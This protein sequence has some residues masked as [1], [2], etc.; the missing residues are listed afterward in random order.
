MNRDACIAFIEHNYFGNVRAGQ[1]EATMDC[2]TPDARVD[3]RHGDNP[4]RRF[5]VRPAR[6]ATSLVDF[7][8]HLCSNYDAWFGEFQHFIDTEANRAASHFVVR[9]TPKPA[10]LYADAG[11]QE[12]LNCN[13]FEFR[14]E[15]I[16][17]MIIYYANPT[18]NPA[19]TTQAPTGYPP[20]KE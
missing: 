6:D 10:G 16:S 2:F 4:L 20:K 14:A 19:A 5:A 7:Y 1:L 15:R 12:L 18:A 8:R 13:F 17:N 11:V 3:I 9:L